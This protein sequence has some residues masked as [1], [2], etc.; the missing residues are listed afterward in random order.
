MGIEERLGGEEVRRLLV[1]IFVIDVIVL[2]VAMV[3]ND[4]LWQIK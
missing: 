4:I 3:L 1:V 2:I